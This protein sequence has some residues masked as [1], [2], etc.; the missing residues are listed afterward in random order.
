[1]ECVDIIFLSQ[2]DVPEHV[3]NIG[4]VIGPLLVAPWLLKKN[5]AH[6]KWPKMTIFGSILVQTPQKW[7]PKTKFIWWPDQSFRMS[8]YR[9]PWSIWC[10]WTRF[11]YCFDDR[12]TSDG[13]MASLKSFSHTENTQKWPY[14]APKGLVRK[15]TKILCFY[16]LWSCWMSRSY[17]GT[18]WYRFRWSIW[19]FWTCFQH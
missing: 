1:M 2:F 13:L 5:F 19:F 12:T 3:F 11:Q 7:F 18:Y 17:F 16:D 14:L 10:P 8:W 9:F 15:Y 6:K 4:L